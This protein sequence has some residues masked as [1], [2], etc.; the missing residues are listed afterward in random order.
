M[1][2]VSAFNGTIH[3]YIKNNQDNTP[4]GNHKHTGEGTQAIENTSS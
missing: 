1:K 3:I 4:T 2:N